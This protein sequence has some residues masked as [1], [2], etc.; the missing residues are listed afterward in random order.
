MI[1]NLTPSFAAVLRSLAL[2]GLAMAASGCVEPSR[3]SV[4][5]RFLKY[6]RLTIASIDDAGNGWSKR[7][8]TLLENR[9]ADIFPG[10][11]VQAQDFVLSALRSA[12]QEG[13]AGAHST[14]ALSGWAGR[15]PLLKADPQTCRAL[16]ASFGVDGMIVVSFQDPRRG[17]SGFFTIRVIDTQTGDITASVLVRTSG[18]TSGSRRSSRGPSDRVVEKALLQLKQAVERTRKAD[19][20]RASATDRVIPPHLIRTRSARSTR[21]PV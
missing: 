9:W 15:G 3:V 11:V 1:Q 5:R 21:V 16:Y 13:G 19:R 7:V 14:K 2:A 20:R 6:D 8:T 17:D 18:T 4:D 12:A 10:Q